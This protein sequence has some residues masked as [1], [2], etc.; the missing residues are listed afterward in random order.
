[1]DYLNNLKT[2]LDILKE[3]Y[4]KVRNPKD[5]RQIKQKIEFALNNKWWLVP[6]NK[7]LL[8]NNSKTAKHEIIRTLNLL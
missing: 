8:S 3:K 7:H 6:L 2:L 5:V 1:M 4:N